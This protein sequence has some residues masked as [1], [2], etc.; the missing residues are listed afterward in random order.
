MRGAG[1]V[2]DRNTVDVMEGDTEDGDAVFTIS[3]EF[4]EKEFDVKDCDGNQIAEIARKRLANIITDKDTCAIT[5]EEG[6]DAAL[7]IAFAVA[8]DEIFRD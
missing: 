1:L 2:F 4:S 7:I 3:G 6:Q 8:I 5:V